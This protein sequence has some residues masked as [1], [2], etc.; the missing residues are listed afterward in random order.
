MQFIINSLIAGATYTLVTLGF[1]LVYG[2][3]KFVNM[4][5]GVLAAVGGYTVFFFTQTIGIDLWVSII[6]GI[7]GAGLVGFLADRFIFSTL[8]I[9]KASNLVMFIASL[10]AFIVLQAVLAMVFTSQFQ[11]IV[12]SV[13][14]P[15]VYEIGSAA[16]THIQLLIIITAL[17]SSFGLVLLLRFTMFGKAVKAIS[18]DEEVA[19][20]IGIDT[21]K[22]IGYVF[23]IGSA[24]AGIAGILIGFDTGIQPTMGLAIL[25]EGATASIIGGIGNLYG[26]IAGSFLLGFVENF[27]IWKIPS[28][29]K[30]A[31][32]FSVLIIFLIFRPQGIFKK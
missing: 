19:K 18:D 1:N 26:G 20:I 10:G 24:I 21:N 7:I 29:W 27:G 12:H 11:S 28:E 17:F 13:D 8:R 3:T 6:V 22:I 30:G 16:I 32:T 23:F 14:S 5:H 31:I 2:A 9:K 4:F 25:L 15:R